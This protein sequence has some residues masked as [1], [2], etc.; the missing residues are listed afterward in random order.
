MHFNSELDS[1]IPLVD[2]LTLVFGKLAYFCGQIILANI[3][4]VVLLLGK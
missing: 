2:L 4:R 1:D 3:N